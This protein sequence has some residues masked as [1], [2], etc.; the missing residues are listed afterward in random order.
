M[1]S[2][3]QGALI[4]HFHSGC[5]H[6]QVDIPYIQ[7]G[8]VRKN[9]LL[10]LK[11]EAEKEAKKNNI[12]ILIDDSPDARV[13]DVMKQQ[14]KLLGLIGKK[15]R[16]TQIDFLQ[17]QIFGCIVYLAQLFSQLLLQL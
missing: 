17:Y 4:L 9:A 10:K 1:M 6:L 15:N 11:R 13:I 7:L 2:L 16:S 3:W 8:S 14:P 5:I 12:A